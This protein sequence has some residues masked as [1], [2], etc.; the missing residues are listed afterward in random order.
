ML[1]IPDE[2][3]LVLQTLL[4]FLNEIAKYHKTNQMTRSN[5][6]VCFSPVIF[7]LNYD[8][9][10]KIKSSH[11]NLL[12]TNEKS[13]SPSLLTVPPQ[14][15]FVQATKPSKSS[16]QLEPI[17]P[18]NC[19]IY[20]GPAPLTP[21]S[22]SDNSTLSQEDSVN[23]TPDIR[24]TNTLTSHSILN[25]TTTTTSI[26]NNTT[27]TPTS[28]ANN[29][30]LS[31]MSA[32]STPA[33]PLSPLNSTQ[34]LLLKQNYKRKYSDKFNKA[35]SSIVSFGAELSSGTTGSFFSDSMKDSLDNL[36][37]MSKVVQLCVADMIK[38][39]MDLFT[40]PI[41]NFEKL[42]LSVS[43]GS[44][45]HNL[46]YVYDSQQHKI[47]KVEFFTNNV[48]IQKTFW[49]YL[50]KYEDVSIY[51]FKNEYVQQQHEQL[52]LTTTNLEAQAQSIQSSNMNSSTPSV[53]S[54]I[55]SAAAN[56]TLTSAKVAIQM[57]NPPNPVADAASVSSSLFMPQKNENF[58]DKLKLWKC[59]T[60]V[61]HQNLT[62][63]KI[64]NR[65]KNER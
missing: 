36:E 44:E 42:K 57:T 18:E 20:F 54:T 65:I 32:S 45:P 62:L 24:T 23:P 48:N 55:T 41:E 16:E 50:D 29:A 19:G 1:L 33:S 63:Q 11:R 31:L 4:L 35:A 15:L 26:C 40:V 17:T 28:L 56:T 58:N 30:N 27:A 6:A 10:K 51:Y 60:L 64:I 13:P 14:P 47:K 43:F 12:I 34:S 52:L 21:S 37:Y 39:S 2:N 3:R 7:S 59:C 49:F 5:L 8:N 38:Y 61:K 25:E 9:K 53:L 46:D 22:L